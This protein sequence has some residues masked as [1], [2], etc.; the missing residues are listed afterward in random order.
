MTRFPFSIKLDPSD[1][2]AFR[3]DGV[4]CLRG[5]LDELEI[6]AL[7]RDVAAQMDTKA[8]S[9]TAYDFED[10]SRQVFSEGTSSVDVGVADRFDISDLQM[11]LDHDLSARPV[12]DDISDIDDN[13]VGTFFYDAAG[14]RFYEG[15][16]SVAL[17]S[18]LPQL[19]AQLLSSCTLN[20]WEDTTFVKSANTGQRTAFHQD[21][22]YFQIKGYKC[23]IVWIALDP[24][25]PETGGMEYIRGSHHW[26][27]SFAPNV[28]ISQS[29][30]P[31]S[32]FERLPDIEA[33][34]DEYDIV[35]F[36]VQPGDV[37]IHHVMTVHGSRGNQSTDR[38]RRAISLRYC[39]DDITYCDRP[40]AMSQP[41][42]LSK[43]TE[44]SCLYSE[45]YPLVWPR[46]HPNAKLAPVYSNVNLEGPLHPISTFT[47]SAK[48]EQWLPGGS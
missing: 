6:E 22:G 28:L 40:G 3:R 42:L 27:E 12:R 1:L 37:I 35:S 20:F 41:Y 10:L 47:P 5:V 23:C 43:P 29:P 9:R 38:N 17:D 18:S 33:N 31:L 19:C 39:G 2:T 30:H 13:S 26:Y 32:P 14:W 45:D 46:P 44:G 7:R 11:I 15:I 4:V 36:D 25:E 21:Y 16:R 48:P 24:V 34:R 8:S